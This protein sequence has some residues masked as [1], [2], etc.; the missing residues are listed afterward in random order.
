[1]L[2][3]IC[4]NGSDDHS[5]QPSPPQTPPPQHQQ[6]RFSQPPS[7]HPS[8]P[9]PPVQNVHPGRLP[10]PWQKKATFDNCTFL[11]PYETERNIFYQQLCGALHWLEECVSKSPH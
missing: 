4:Y 7:L 9:H 8:P 1:M 6:P 10:V 5:T 11:Q 2:S 3:T